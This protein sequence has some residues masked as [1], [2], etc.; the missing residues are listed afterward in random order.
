[1][2][3]SIAEQNLLLGV[4]ALQLN[5]IR[6]ESLLDAFRLWTD[7][8]TRG[9]GTI[10]R[11]QHALTADDADLLALV[12]ESLTRQHGN[13]PVLPLAFLL[14][15]EIVPPLV[16]LDDPELLQCLARLGKGPSAAT[17]AL[18]RIERT[19]D[20]PLTPTETPTVQ[21]GPGRSSN[22]RAPLPGGQPTRFRIVRR[23][24]RGG[25]GEIF[26]ALDE[27]LQRE[28]ALKEMQAEHVDRPDS[29]VR[30]L[31][32]GEITGRLEH[33]GIV[34]VYGL[35][36]YS[37]GRPF[38]A[39]RFIKGE[40]LNLAIHR[41]HTA[42]HKDAGTR[43]LEL[44]KLLA[45]FV[46]V[47]NAVEYAHSK[48]VLHRDLKPDNVMLG[49][50]GETLV[51]DWGLAKQLQNVD[52]RLTSEKQAGN[53]P[54]NQQSPTDNRQ[55][56]SGSLMGQVFG[57]PQFMSPEQAS[58]RIDLL[59]PASDVYSLGA[60]LY[61][62][63]TGQAPVG[64]DADVHKLLRMVQSGSITPPRQIMASV[65]RALE[66]VCLKAMALKP[67][68]RYSSARELAS[69]VERWLA[70]EPVTAWREPWLVRVRRWAR[71]HRTT[72]TAG[73]VLCLTAVVVLSISYWLLVREQGRTEQ[74]INDRA[75][76][77]VNALLEANPRAV[78]ALLEGLEPFR[79]RVR[80]R[81]RQ[82]RRQASLLHQTR[83]SIALLADNHPGE[84]AFLRQRLVDPAVEPEEF[85][86]LR[87]TL[88]A[89]QAALIP[90]LWT[91]VDRPGIAAEQ[92]FR[93][94]VA[95]AHFDPDNSRWENDAPRVVEQFLQADP[96]HV[97]IWTN[98]LYPVRDHLIEHLSV[99]FSDPHF[100]AERRVAANVL[101]E[102]AADRPGLLVQL[103]G[104]AS[105]FQVGLLL[106]RLQA[107][108]ND[109]L[110][111]LRMDLQEAER[112]SGSDDDRDSK[113]HRQANV[114]IV[115]LHLG[116]PDFAWKLLRH[117]PHPDA[118]TYLIH[119][120][121]SLDVDP[122]LLI[123]RL[124]VESDD[125]V[126]QA[127][128]LALGGYT[129]EQLSRSSREAITPQLLS[130]YLDHPDPGLHGAIDWLLRHGREGNAA[131]KLDW[132]ETP[133][134]EKLDG[135]LRGEQ[136]GKRRWYLTPHGETMVLLGP[137][138]FLMG[139]PDSET[140]HES[141]ETLHRRH[142]ARTF[143]I[144]AHEVTNRQLDRFLKEHPEIH[145]P[146]QERYS[147]K[148]DC[149]A[150]NVSWY[151][152]A[153]YCRWLSEKENIPE[154]QMCFPPIEEIF[155]CMDGKT[156][157]VMKPNY[158][159]R[160]GYRLPTEAEWEYACRGRTHSTR[161]HG[162]SNE[163]MRHYAWDVRDALARTWPVGQKKP[164]DFGLF[165]MHG[166]VAEWCF[167]LYERY[168]QTMKSV[169]D[170]EEIKEITGES[171]YVI[172]GAPFQPRPEPL[173]SAYRY[174]H[175]PMDRFSTNGFRV[176]RTIR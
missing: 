33:P 60:T 115:L 28:V 61:H 42:K 22:V 16:E 95:L 52:C 11:E 118:R 113:G 90:G 111:L 160:T 147:P 83:A 156:A 75:L 45:R 80:Q 12:V 135:M 63:L 139:S 87:D 31:L 17:V 19:I 107:L 77:Q 92:R 112:T 69:D 106:P 120:F 26:I 13:D 20:H 145:H 99:V 122:E 70:D 168:P 14:P 64:A 29:R 155:K 47:C 62:L 9:L 37:D 165:D 149:P 140:G 142:I 110:P 49:P 101:R 82:V 130:W 161:P 51:V 123:R 73:A 172:R 114:A 85:L 108:R 136:A 65:P 143:A 166:N 98:A 41:F 34:P 40:S 53:A 58:G 39:M 38:Y 124:R 8:R 158:L 94:L 150:V 89:H 67:E 125:G 162:V 157:L 54:A 24:A 144:S 138:E 68:D 163:L 170:D 116:E 5:F 1:M 102:Y 57:T 18:P 21:I 43:T 79:E 7:D 66:A 151:L 76:A 23:H 91:E 133:A 50:Y 56:A 176:V 153:L 86:L 72:V 32:E 154:E 167:S 159:K 117:N 121:A 175:K 100:P 44:R 103:L 36:C 59:G 55:S 15:A 25:L 88:A 134:L 48:G 109:V 105:P 141:D 6:Q 78:P 119:L 46:A 164:N 104:T 96:L 2:P 171:N 81:L 169:E 93:V 128:V 127:L 174:Y 97:G 152:A 173:R 131:R 35:G 84:V 129:D 132:R 126:R 10:L 3:P 30:F 137:D 4:L 146:Y 148:S 71:R 27:E 74:A